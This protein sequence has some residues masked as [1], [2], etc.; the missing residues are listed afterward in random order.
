MMMMM[1]DD[2]DGGGVGAGIGGG[3]GWENSR[4]IGETHRGGGG[5]MRGVEWRGVERAEGRPV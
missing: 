1:V 2:D 3:D 5:K 4:G